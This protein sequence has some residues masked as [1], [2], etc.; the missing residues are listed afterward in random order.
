M[1]RL[2]CI[3][4]TES[5]HPEVDLQEVANDLRKLVIDTLWHAQAGH[6]GGSLSAVEILAALYFSVLRVDP[7][8][9]EWA[10][11]RP[12][13]PLQ[14]TRR[15]RLLRGPR[16]RG[17]F[18]DERCC[19]YD[20]LDSLL[21]A[22]PDCTRPAS[23]CASGS[24]GQGLSAGLGMALGARLDGPRR[25]ST[26]CWATASCR[27]G[28]SGRRPWRRPSSAWQP[29]AIVDYNRVQLTGDTCDVMPI[30]PLAD[31]WRAFNWNVLE[32]D[33]HD[34]PHVA[35]A[36]EAAPRRAAADRRHRAHGQGQGRLVH[37]GHHAWHS[38]LVR[39]DPPRALAELDAA[40]EGVA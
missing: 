21:Q 15:G 11:P 2:G 4:S 5:P 38:A 16:A 34:V 9:P 14:G 6:P 13:R 1:E 23:T 29:A 20:E 32:V 22:H 8:D 30:E 24:L 33:G 10:G 25:A 26:C 18:P 7:A 37:G 19:T 35:A 31:K 40:P 12:L 27:R 36:C 28:R 3:A 17:F 39:E